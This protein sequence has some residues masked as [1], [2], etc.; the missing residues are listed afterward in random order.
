[1]TVP[2]L[3]R[4]FAATAATSTL[5]LVAACGSETEEP[6]PPDPRP[7]DDSGQS[8]PGE[9][10]D[11]TYTATGTYP[12]PDGTGTVE[13]E[14]TLADNAIADV[15]VTPQASG[16]NSLQFQTQFAHGIAEEVVGLPLDEVRVDKVAGSSLTG[17]GFNAAIEQIKDDAAV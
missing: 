6:A 4:L 16:G 9:Y 5:A 3:R 13:V 15:T 14:I 7:G 10:A 17:T 12:N 1:M 11:G 2:T 8:E